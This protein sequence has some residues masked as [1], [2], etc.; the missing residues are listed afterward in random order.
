[1]RKWT[2]FLGAAIVLMATTAHAGATT[3]AEVDDSPDF[4]PG[5]CYLFTPDPDTELIWL[6]AIH[7]PASGCTEFAFDGREIDVTKLGE[8]LLWNVVGFDEG[9]VFALRG[10]ADSA[11]YS[12]DREA[13]EN[14][15]PIVSFLAPEY[16]SAFGSVDVNLSVVGTQAP[17]EGIDVTQITVR[18][19]GIVTMVDGSHARFTAAVHEEVEALLPGITPT[20]VLSQLRLRAIN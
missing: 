18:G 4:L 15:T 12:Y 14:G 13:V 19:Q 6:L 5:I 1:M 20:K 9:D 11:I 7:D 8:S 2:A 16:L 3:G 10:V 17:G